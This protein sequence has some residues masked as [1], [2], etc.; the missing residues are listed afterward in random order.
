M[1]YVKL[2]YI[3]EVTGGDEELLLELIEIFFDQYKEMKKMILE[4]LENKDYDTIRQVSHKIK[5]SL[6][7]FGAHEV[8]MRFEKMEKYKNLQK[9][10]D[11]GN[12]IHKTLDMCEQVKE[13][14]K[15][16]I[17]RV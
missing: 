15:H 11:L 12:Y 9:F 16:Y 3:N 7:T 14:L 4:A 10:E 5:S 8:A 13:E 1:V 17:S 6:R 2:D